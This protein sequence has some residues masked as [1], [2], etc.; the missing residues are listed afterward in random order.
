MG[1]PFNKG[2]LK[3]A[4]KLQKK[5]M[6]AQNALEKKEVEAT[7][8]GGLVTAR[9]NGRHQV[10][11]L[12]LK[13]EALAMGDPELLADAIITAINKAQGEIAE[14]S[15]KMMGQMTGGLGIPGF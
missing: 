3:K 10:V 15:E 11:A 2:A 7:A 4:R 14:H 13:E 1:F 12:T 9:V 6:D 8:G 5:M